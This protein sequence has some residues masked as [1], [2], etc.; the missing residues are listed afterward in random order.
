MR[1][2]RVAAVVLAGL[3]LVG[4][5]DPGPEP[6]EI[7][8]G[9]AAPLERWPA[10][11]HLTLGGDFDDDG[12]AEAGG[13]CSGVVVAPQWVLSAAHCGFSD[14]N[15]RLDSISVRVGTADLRTGGETIAAA[16]WIAAPQW[17]GVRSGYR[18]D[19]MLVRLSR[20]T[21]Q[22]PAAVAGATTGW[23]SPVGAA[24]AAGFGSVN[25][26]GT[27]AT[28]LLQE[29][30]LALQPQSVCGRLAGYDPELQTCAHTPDRAGAC[31]GD[32]GGPLVQFDSVSGVPVL[33][34][35][36][37]FGITPPPFS[38]DTARPGYFSLVPSFAAWI[39]SVA[40]VAPVL[41]TPP[42][43][44]PPPPPVTAD[45]ST[46]V[47][48]PDTVAP[49]IAAARLSSARLRRRAA[50]LSFRLSEPA[51]VRLAV[52]RRR[53]GGRL[54]GLK[55]VRRLTLPAGLVR[56]AFRP[57]L[58]GRRLTRGRYVLRVRAVD[59][60]GNAA[61]SVSLAFRVLRLP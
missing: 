6:R 12:A 1:V 9:S 36:T 58:R 61:R 3:A 26:L 21:A 24:N 59:A 29:A 4:G 20:P 22:P 8:G 15:R 5:G 16:D 46:P 10:I 54:R 38:C 2:R 23:S 56:R 11:A 13:A 33:Y 34:G 49:V 7:V 39:Q 17:N 45:A 18:G 42:P 43:A 25:E 35:L 28:P 40:G 60:A 44:P 31:T 51:T 14:A 30:Y 41:P 48:P 47:A 50:R 37:S 52:L 19:A 27:T 53:R 57:R 55:P 32:S